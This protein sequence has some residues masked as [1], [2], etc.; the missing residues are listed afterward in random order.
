MSEK[1]TLRPRECGKKERKS[2]LE[3]S[4]GSF[5]ILENRDERHG[6]G[7]CGTQCLGKFGEK[8]TGGCKEA[9]GPSG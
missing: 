7:N 3:R 9:L 1:V 5:G 2:F 4:R 8:K 6:N